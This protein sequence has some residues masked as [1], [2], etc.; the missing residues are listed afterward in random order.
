MLIIGLVILA[1]LLFIDLFA[2]GYAILYRKFW[3]GFVSV[4]VG[5]YLV[6]LAV[7]TIKYLVEYGVSI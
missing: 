3:W 1:C 7:Q 4:G 5:A 6:Y 2:F